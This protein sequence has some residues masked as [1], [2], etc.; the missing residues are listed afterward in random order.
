MRTATVFVPLADSVFLWCVDLDAAGEGD[1]RR[2]VGEISADERQRAVRLRS[3]LVARRWVRARGA[4][5]E[6]LA[7]AVGSAPSDVDFDVSEA[8]KPSL[9]GASRL[10]FNLAHSARWALVGLTQDRDVG[11]DVERVREGLHEAAIARR[12][13]GADAAAALATRAAAERTGQFFRQWVRHEAAV[14]C[15]GIGL[16]D[17]VGRDVRTGLWV[18]DVDVDAG[19]AAAY[20]LDGPDAALVVVTNFEWT[21]AD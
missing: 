15:R 5:R 13:L 8:G 7:K 20:A 3:T 4:L 1:D 21:G 10:R 14:K 6:I 12:I 2:L 18:D 9:A 16:V 17:A 11:V 19:Y